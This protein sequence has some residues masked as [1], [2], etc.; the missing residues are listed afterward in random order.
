MVRT[1]LTNTAAIARRL[2]NASP[3][4]AGEV[5]DDLVRSDAEPLGV[6]DH[7][8]SWSAESQQTAVVEPGELGRESGEAA[9]GLL[10]GDPMALADLFGQ[11]LGRVPPGGQEFRVRATVGHPEEHVRVLDDLLEQI[12]CALGRGG[13]EHGA[14]TVGDGD[15]EHRV[16]RVL[17]SGVGDLPDGHLPEAFGL[18]RPR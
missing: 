11:R 14:Q 5:L 15:V 6:V 8:V 17:P 1:P 12:G 9:M 10:V 13:E 4:A 16:D 2:L 18:G 7:D 3:L